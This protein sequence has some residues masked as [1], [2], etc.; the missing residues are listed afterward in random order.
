LKEY[1]V[2]FIFTDEYH[3]PVEG[4]SYQIGSKEPISATSKPIILYFWMDDYVREW[5][6]GS[7]KL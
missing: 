4:K 2:A 3:T 5:D 6:K 7:P 1:K